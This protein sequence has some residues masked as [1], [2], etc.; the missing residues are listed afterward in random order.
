M[1]R[2]LP[3]FEQ[4]IVKISPKKLNGIVYRSGITTWKVLD[5]D[6]NEIA[7]EDRG[8]YPSSLWPPT[9]DDNY[10]YIVDSLS[11]CVR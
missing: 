7:F 2:L 4:K 10:D 9:N 6:C 5:D 3:H 8:R 11:R 1:N